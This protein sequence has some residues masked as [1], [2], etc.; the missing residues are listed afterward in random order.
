MFW[1]ILVVI[2][3]AALFVLHYG[4]KLAFYYKDP[5]ASPY[6]YVVDDQTTACKEILDC[7][8]G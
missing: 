7:T 3:A 8:I 5:L 1:I 6:D 4:Y 2:L